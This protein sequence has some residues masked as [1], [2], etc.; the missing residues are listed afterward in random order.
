MHHI[1]TQ[2]NVLRGTL[3]SVYDSYI[4]Q[5]NY[6]YRVYHYQYYSLN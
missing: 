4:C 2:K 3:H 6:I 1:S 5:N